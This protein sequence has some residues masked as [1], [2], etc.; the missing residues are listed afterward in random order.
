MYYIDHI[1]DSDDVDDI[2]HIDHIDQSVM[3]PP[4]APP[5][6]IPL[7]SSSSATSSFNE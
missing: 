1:D 6:I 2:D 4:N 5:V 3:E 7:Y